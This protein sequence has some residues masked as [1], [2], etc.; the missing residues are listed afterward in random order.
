[1]LSKVS[2][3]KTKQ[4]LIQAI[5][6]TRNPTVKVIEVLDRNA[7]TQAKSKIDT[8]S[9]QGQVTVILLKDAP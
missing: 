8:L 2:S 9:R 1:M 6:A 7:A 3:P 5:Q 4:S